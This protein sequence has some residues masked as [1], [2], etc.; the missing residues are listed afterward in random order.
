MPELSSNEKISH[1]RIVSKI[2][3]GGMGEV[4]LAK[5]TRLDRPIALKILPAD[6]AADSER[7]RRFVQEAKATSALNHP[8]I[9]TIYEIGETDDTHFIAAEYIE[10]ETLRERLKANNFSANDCLEVGIQVA[11][12]LQAAHCVNIVH[13]DIKPENIMIRPDGLVK[14]LDFGIAKLVEMRNADFGMRNAEAETLRQPPQNNPQSAIP[15]PQSTSP[16]VIIGTA[17]YMSP[18]QAQGKAVDARSDIFSCGVVLY[19]MLAGCQPFAGETAMDA[20]GRILHKEP[21]PL[22]QLLPE[23]SAEFERIIN[24]ALCKDCEERYQSAKDLLIDLKELKEELSFQSKLKRATQSSRETEAQTQI[25]KA[26][27]DEN[28]R[29]TQGTSYA[30]SIAVLPFA[31]L[32]NDAENEYFCD[33]LAEELLNALAKIEDLK[34]AARTSAFSFKNKNVEI[35]EIG[36]TLNV[37]TVLEGSVRKSGNRLRITV[38]LIN[39]ADGYHLWSERYDREMRDIFDV[40]DEITLAVVDALKLKLFGEEKAALLKRGT[41]NTEAYE[42]YLKGLYHNNKYTPEG[43]TRAIEYF[44]EAIRQEP[45]Y[46]AAFA[47]KARCQHYLYYYAVVSPDEIVDRWRATTNRALELDEQ[48]ADAH[49]SLAKFYF[50]RERDWAQAEREFKRAIELNP[51]SA[52]AR[53]FYGMFLASRRRM[54]EAVREG[55]I[56]LE[57]DPLSL[58]AKL[59]IGWIYWSASRF[60]DTIRQAE[61][62]IEI[63]PNFFGA[64]FHLGLAHLGKGKT[65]R[66]VEAFQKSMTLNATPY[67][68]SFS[69]WAYAL[70][71]K[72]E[73]AFAVINQL[74]DEKKQQFTPAFNVARVYGGLNETD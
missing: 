59:H 21:T 20:I 43:W 66:A 54:D 19:E 45:E 64:Y 74:L 18:E 62:M 40:Q 11:S 6:F 24:K 1:Y 27:T 51:N 61:Q 67:V 10:G 44:D 38:Q 28:I 29:A 57:L 41:D 15:N 72:R 52:D 22:N 50:Y 17:N 47:A 68:L 9:I 42:C 12:A 73:K 36:K 31:N 23:I 55:E 69:G 48:A 5:D 4:F 46:A 56:A 14:I 71:G 70:A 65:E 3:A 63:E 34:V 39:A 53:Q 49:L 35:S 30:N 58:P 13:R 25:I 33:G 26:A 8:N 2:G 37:K 7:M 16:G 32:S 60:D